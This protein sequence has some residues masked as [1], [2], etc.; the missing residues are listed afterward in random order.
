ME[1]LISRFRSY[2]GNPIRDDD[3]PQLSPH[4]RRS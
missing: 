3:I 4:K 2:S 1:K